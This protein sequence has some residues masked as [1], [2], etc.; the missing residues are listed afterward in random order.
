MFL[1]WRC[2]EGKGDAAEITRLSLVVL[3][4]A[5]AI[6]LSLN[7]NNCVYGSVIF[8]FNKEIK[9]KKLINI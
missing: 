2:F 9:I 3:F 8:R 1:N 5:P 6:H 4:K 7:Y